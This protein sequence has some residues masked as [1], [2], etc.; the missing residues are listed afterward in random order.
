MDDKTE[1]LKKENTFLRSVKIQVPRKKL[2][3]KFKEKV[4]DQT[5]N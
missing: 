2:Q 4:K 5:V 3:D 1:N